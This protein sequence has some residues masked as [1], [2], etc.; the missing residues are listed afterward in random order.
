MTVRFLI[1]VINGY[2]WHSMLALYADF[3]FLLQGIP[4]LW[5]LCFD[6]TFSLW[7]KLDGKQVILLDEQR[8]HCVEDFFLFKIR[9]FRSFN[10]SF[11]SSV[12][13]PL[14][15]LSHLLK[16]INNVVY[17]VLYTSPYKTFGEL[18][19]D[20]VSERMINQ[21]SKVTH[22]YYQFYLMLK[23][24]LH[25]Y[26]NNCLAFFKQFCQSQ[27]KNPLCKTSANL[28]LEVEGLYICLDLVAQKL[29]GNY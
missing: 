22:S 19:D 18:G 4:D 2:F 26:P 10:T 5:K 6:L 3:F 24:S 29:V 13:L 16:K 27:T 12:R 8:Y 23:G 28:M 1:P 7:T 9:S 25:F 17:K 11:S 20:Q 15:L 14:S 21:T